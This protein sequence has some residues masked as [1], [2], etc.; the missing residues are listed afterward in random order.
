MGRGMLAPML[1]D[2][3]EL[4]AERPASAALTQSV[5]NHPRS[6][7]AHLDS[8]LDEACAAFLDPSPQAHRRAIDRLWDAWE[9]AKTV[10]AQDKR[11][12]AGLMLDGAATPG[13]PFRALLEREAKE[14][15][16]IGNQFHIRHHETTKTPLDE[17]LHVDYL[18]HRMLAML[19]LVLR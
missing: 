12:G 11:V 13:S 17:A 6:T 2:L 18:F 3:E 10:Q 15:T 4:A 14:L 9:R 8:L 19:Q 5:R 16:D 1:R 7:D